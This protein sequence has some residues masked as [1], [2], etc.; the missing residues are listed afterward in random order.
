MR[1][2][3]YHL[4]VQVK[5]SINPISW[6]RVS[7]YRLMGPQL[8]F[9]QTVITE[10]NSIFTIHSTFHR[11]EVTSLTLKH[12][13]QLTKDRVLGHQCCRRRIM[14]VFGAGQGDMWVLYVSNPFH[15]S[16]HELNNDLEQWKSLKSGEFHPID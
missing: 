2:C 7:F 14:Y 16:L 6:K 9:Y 13:A 1:N 10:F 8:H 5:A 12:S 3:F 15:F 4:F 11:A